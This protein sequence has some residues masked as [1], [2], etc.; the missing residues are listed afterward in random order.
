M[1]CG[2]SITV[3]PCIRPILKRKMVPQKSETVSQ[4]YWLGR[5]KLTELRRFKDTMSREWSTSPVHQKRSA[6]PG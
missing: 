4:N 6:A 2:A 3:I 5:Q 1:P